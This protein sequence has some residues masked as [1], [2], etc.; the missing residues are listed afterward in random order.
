MI[1]FKYNMEKYLYKPNYGKKDYNFIMAYPAN[2]SLALAS[3]G[4]LWLFKIVDTFNGI[5]AERIY[6]DSAKINIKN[7][8]AIAFSMSFDFDFMGVFEILE[9]NNIPIRR[10][11]RIDNHPLVF[12][13]GPVITTNFLPYFDIFD[14]FILGDGEEIFPEILTILAKKEEKDLTLKKLAD[15]DG[16][17]VPDYSKS[18]NKRTC[19]LKDIIY[20]P[21]LSEDSYFKDTFI[22]EIERGCMNRCAFCSA[23]YLNLPMRYYDYNKITKI[24][25]LGLKYT[26][27]IALLGAQLNA[28]PDFEKILEYI[29][30]KIQD[31][32]KIE[33]GISSL[34]TDAITPNLIK[35]LVAGGQKTST[36]AIEAAT[37][38]LRKFINK[39]L[40]D[41]QIFNAV[42][43][44]REN[45]LN[46][47]KIYSMIGIPTETDEDIEAF[48][49][50]AQKLK[51]ENKGFKLTF[52]FSSFVP[53][54]HTPLQWAKTESVNYIEKKQNYLKKELAKIGV[55]S[56]FSSAKWDFRQ[57]VL[58]RGNNNLGEAL[59]NIYKNKGSNKS[60][61]DLFKLAGANPKLGLDE[62]DKDKDLCWEIEKFPENKVTLI[63]EIERLYKYS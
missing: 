20:T 14:F 16:I 48:I 9:K 39:N 31:G 54:P 5:N 25:D 12:A 43:T 17:Y 30:D 19:K 63:K 57:A 35:I 51:N 33:L 40:K 11:E 13:G 21:I 7:I 62:L 49:K 53:K 3:I 56:K 15:L 42:K 29:Y 4:Y 18:V 6:T 58:S 59:I 34:R 28:H 41:E 8:N 50:L 23:S 10:K 45:G 2:R 47:L 60:Y 55:D 32:N 38:R 27:K 61:N 26:N 24:I 22:I 37:E 46:G 52:S 44:C 36:I 1:N